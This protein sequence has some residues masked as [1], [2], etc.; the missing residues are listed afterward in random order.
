MKIKVRSSKFDRKVRKVWEVDLVTQSSSLIIVR[1][2]F[3]SD[4][5]HPG[6]GKI[7]RDTISTE[8]Y[9]TD[10]WYNVFR[11]QEPSG[12]FRNYYCNIQMP[13]SFDGK[14]IDYVDLDIDLVAGPDMSYRVLD[15]EEFLGNSKKYSYPDDVIQNAKTALGEMVLMIQTRQFPFLEPTLALN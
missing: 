9:W 11:F 4:V 15:C 6:L 7:L 14:V 8:Y 5:E 1:G 13:A 10:R 12:K 2:N 3:A